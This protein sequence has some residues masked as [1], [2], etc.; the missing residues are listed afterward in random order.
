MLAFASPS[1]HAQPAPA[2]VVTLRASARCASEIVPRLYL[3]DYSSATD[4]RTLARLRVTHVLSCM[5]DAPPAPRGL[6]RMHVPVSDVPST[7]LGAWFARTNVW[8]ADAMADPENVVLVH[9]LMV[10]F[11]LLVTV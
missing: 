2:A 5:E 9:C 7:D 6:A 4:A 11:V 8:I 3:A 10:C 1:V